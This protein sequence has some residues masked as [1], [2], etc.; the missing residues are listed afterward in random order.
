MCCAA[1]ILLLLFYLHLQ[2]C[3]KK[4]AEKYSV[5]SGDGDGGDGEKDGK[6]ITN[7][8]KWCRR[9]HTAFLFITLP[10]HP[11]QHQQ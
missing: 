7:L 5:V 11:T 2:N 8:K 10:S 1:G 4:A 9:K 3:L 6:K